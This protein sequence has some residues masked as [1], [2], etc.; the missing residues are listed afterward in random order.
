M[1]PPSCLASITTAATFRDAVNAI[2]AAHVHRIFVVDGEGRPV[3]IISLT[4]I[5]AAAMTL[6]QPHH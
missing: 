2:V 5:I 4:D 1:Q 6:V 3:G